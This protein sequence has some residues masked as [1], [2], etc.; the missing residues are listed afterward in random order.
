MTEEVPAASSMPECNGSVAAEKGP[1]Q[2]ISVI[3]EAARSVGTVPYANA[4]S[5]PDVSPEEENPAENRNS[6]SGG[7]DGEKQ[8]EGKV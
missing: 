4:D 8:S 1:F 3:D 2:V 6:L 5:S 7:C